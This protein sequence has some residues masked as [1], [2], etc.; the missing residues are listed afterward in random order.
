MLERRSRSTANKTQHRTDRHLKDLPSGA[1]ETLAWQ[2]RVCCVR[3]VLTAVKEEDGA[4]A[5]VVR[6]CLLSMW[7][8]GLV[9]HRVDG[10]GKMPK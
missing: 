6:H 4:V 8:R 10:N 7:N 1:F 2:H 9:I 5:H 3:V